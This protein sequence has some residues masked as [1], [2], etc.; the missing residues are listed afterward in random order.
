MLIQDI[1]KR[2][3]HKVAIYVKRQV[4]NQDKKRCLHATEVIA[5]RHMIVQDIEKYLQKVKEYS[6]TVGYDEY[7]RKY[8]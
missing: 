2:C 7:S 5:R 4:M 8:R 6:R 3:L 1:E